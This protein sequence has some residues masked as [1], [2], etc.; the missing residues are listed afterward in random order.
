MNVPFETIFNLIIMIFED[1]DILIHFLL[2]LEIVIIPLRT[3]K[4]SDFTSLVCYHILSL[5]NSN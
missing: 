3:G 2:M 4:E 1:T 5:R